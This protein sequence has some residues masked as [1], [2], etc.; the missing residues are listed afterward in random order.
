M[1]TFLINSPSLVW[2]LSG[3]SREIIIARSLGISR[4]CGGIL[5]LELARWS[6]SWWPGLVTRVTIAMKRS[7]W[8]LPSSIRVLY[9]IVLVFDTICYNLFVQQWQLQCLTEA[10]QVCATA[11]DAFVKWSERECWLIPPRACIQTT[12]SQH[13][14]PVELFQAATKNNKATPWH[15]LHSVILFQATIT[16]NEATQSNTLHSGRLV[17][18]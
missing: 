16:S 14:A 6:N 7:R 18:D 17:L 10:M 5:S 2:A 4:R 15:T 8:T 13:S 12:R 9:K 1:T 3:H 11:P